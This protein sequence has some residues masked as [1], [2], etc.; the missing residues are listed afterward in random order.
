MDVAL[1]PDVR[2]IVTEKFALAA[3]L[4]QSN[5]PTAVAVLCHR[6][7]E[8][9]H[10]SGPAGKATDVFDVVHLQRLPLGLSYVDQVEHIAQL[11]ARPPLK[12][13]CEFVI[14]ATGVGRPVAD[15]FDDAGLRPTQVTITAGDKQLPHGSRR[16]GIPKG[17]LISG[18]DAR[19]HTGELRFAAAL[20][21]A[22][23]MA[24]ELKDFRRKVSAA[25]RY[26]YDARVGRHDDLVLAV[27]LGLW[28]L[29]GKPKPPVARTGQQH[30]IY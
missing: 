4:G 2:E 29:A 24:E 25:G 21:D 12:S 23:A 5:D 26:S 11:L 15:L 20:H 30:R 16:W 14:D 18:L 19:L 10:W 13:G 6:H 8:F 22:D 27:A 28:M 3:D 17:T 1:A 9:M 7:V